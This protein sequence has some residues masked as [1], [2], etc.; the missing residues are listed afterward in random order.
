M[1]QSASFL[2]R[3]F[4]SIWILHLQHGSLQHDAA[5]KGGLLYQ[6]RSPMTIL[7]ERESVLANRCCDLRPSAKSALHFVNF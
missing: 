7:V 5:E 3:W 4:F 2:F 6:R 1:D